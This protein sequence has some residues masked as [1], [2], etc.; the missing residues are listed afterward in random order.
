[1][2]VETVPIGKRDKA[3]K[4][5]DIFLVTFF[6]F[7]FVFICYMFDLEQLV[8]SGEDHLYNWPLTD[9]PVW[10]PKFIVDLNHW[11]GTTMDPA[12]LAR[13]TWWQATIWID[14]ILF[15]PFYAIAT[16]AFIRG[17]NW[18]RM[19]SIIWASVMLTNV[20]II[21]INEFVLYPTNDMWYGMVLAN[22]LWI[23]TPILVY[24]RMALYPQTF[25]GERYRFKEKAPVE[26]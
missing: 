5:I 1:M 20:T 12:L 24:I 13:E 23:L 18:I 10:P 7:N 16:Y 9:Y 2:R 11:V 21:M 22:L 19:P 14:V 8:V 17:K 15:G 26:L 3:R 6:I 25:G 4:I